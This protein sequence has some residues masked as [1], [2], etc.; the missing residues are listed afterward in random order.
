VCLRPQAIKAFEADKMAPYVLI[1]RYILREYVEGDP[2]TETKE[3][4]KG[5]GEVNASGTQTNAP[6]VVPEGG[7]TPQEAG[8]AESNRADERMELEEVPAGAEGGQIRREVPFEIEF[9]KE[10]EGLE[11]GGQRTSTDGNEGSGEE[12]SEDDQDDPPSA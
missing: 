6:V 1:K 10:L 8:R 2:A 4:D 9:Q 3:K 7:E 12:E 5:H 11:E